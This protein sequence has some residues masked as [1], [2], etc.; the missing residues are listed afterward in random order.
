MKDQSELDEH[1]MVAVHPSRKRR[2][3]GQ[4]FRIQSVSGEYI[5]GRVILL[6]VSSDADLLRGKRPPWEPYPGFNL[7]YI[8]NGICK[9]DSI[10]DV[11]SLSAVHF[12]YV[13]NRTCWTRGYFQ[14]IR[15]DPPQAYQVFPRHLFCIDTRE[16]RTNGVQYVCDE[17]GNPAKG[18]PDTLPDMNVAGCDY[19]DWR[20]RERAATMRV[21]D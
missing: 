8:Y 1:F 21:I 6:D 13:V 5:Y 12:Q 19:F 20:L 16:V 3:I 11:A 17:R 2:K 10:P 18:D 7:I 4:L 9:T 15:Y 14:P